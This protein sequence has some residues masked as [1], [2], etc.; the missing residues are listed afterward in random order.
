MQTDRR[1][2]LFVAGNPKTRV[3]YFNEDNYMGRKI[4]KSLSCIDY[5]MQEWDW[6]KNTLDPTTLGFQSNKKVWWKCKYGH[7]WEAKISNR[8]NGR[9]C[10][11]CRCRLKTSFQEQSFYFYIKKLFADTLNSY[12]AFFKNGMELDIFIPSLRMGIEYDGQ[13]WHNEK[14]I[15]KETR[16]YDICK[17]NNVFLLRIVENSNRPKVACDYSIFVKDSKNN[18]YLDDAIRE[19][20]I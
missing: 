16:K 12:T 6:A 4:T 8:Y 19:C 15:Q 9:D 18:Q 13:A 10:P 2:P 3:K 11:I 5:L 20:L 14:S 17:N 7:S 1:P